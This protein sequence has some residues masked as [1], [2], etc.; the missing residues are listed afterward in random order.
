MKTR[1]RTHTC[2]ELRLAD[3]GKTVTLAGWVDRRRDHG[4]VVFVDLRDRYGKTQVLLDAGN[5]ALRAKIDELRPE[6]VIAV[7]GEIVARGPEW[8][9]PKLATGEIEVAAR[10]LEILNRAATPPFDVGAPAD[11][12]DLVALESRFK[13]RYID[14]RRPVMQQRLQF[15]HR[16]ILAIRN[17]FDSL[18]FLD[19]ETPI[20]TKSTPEGARDYLVP[21]RVNRG[22]FYALPQSPQLFKQLLMVAGF[23]R[24]YQIA[25]C[26]RDEDLR[27]D[28][29]PEFTQLDFEMSFVDEE[30]IYALVE[31]LMAHLWKTLFPDRKLAVPF[32]RVA[33]ETAV[34]RYGIDKPDLRFGLEIEDVTEI[35]GRSSAQFFQDAARSSERK[36]GAV[37]ALRLPGAAERFSRKDLDALPDLVREKGAKGVS[38]LKIEAA[39]KLTGSVAK[40]FDAALAAELLAKLGAAAGDLV[41][42]V[43]DKN[44]DVVAAAL[45]QL[46]LHAARKLELVDRTRDEFLWVTEFPFFEHDPAD[47]TYIACRHPFT[48]PKDDDVMHLEEEPLKVHTK[49][50]DL[51]LNGMELGSGSIRNHDTALQERVFAILGYSKEEAERRF[52]FLLEALRSGA[53]PHGGAA[54][55]LDRFCGL[56]QGVEMREVIAFPK[57]SKA[58][59]PM[60]LAPSTVDPAQLATLGVKTIE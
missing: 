9:N 29:Q 25:R 57:T 7:T 58:Q 60:T 5:A 26:F 36:G 22:S 10:S 50:Y 44:R 17:Y 19:V 14:L 28:R 4:G 41:L 59:D 8:K 1:I 55:G 3:A 43:A 2:G 56:L 54:L 27:A 34:L 31:G 52:G 40:F 39:G 21:S 12:G 37:R 51:V 32:R 49:A 18:G 16:V 47:N 35:A 48:R 11:E 38:W 15:R 42:F 24:Y 20:L 53:P 13:Y 33:Y 30:D 46:R 45:G 23:D 6:F